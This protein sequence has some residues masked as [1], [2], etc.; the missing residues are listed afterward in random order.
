[1]K[2]PVPV[3]SFNCLDV[4]NKSE[5]TIPHMRCC[6][7]MCGDAHSRHVHFLMIKRPNCILQLT[8]GPIASSTTL[9]TTL[10]VLTIVSQVVSSKRFLK[11]NYNGKTICIVQV[12]G[13]NIYYIWFNI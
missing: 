9:F 3:T 11:L 8:D 5:S 12:I 2:T 10:L 13:Y 6:Q 1:M 4:Q 7:I